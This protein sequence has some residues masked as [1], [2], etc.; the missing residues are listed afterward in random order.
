MAEAE[1]ETNWLTNLLGHE[2]DALPPFDTDE[3]KQLRGFAIAG[4]GTFVLVMLGLAVSSILRRDGTI[5]LDLLAAAAGLWIRSVA[6]RCVN[7]K[8]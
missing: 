5:V 3:R 2:G 6:L 1:Q 4:C 7:R 8:Y